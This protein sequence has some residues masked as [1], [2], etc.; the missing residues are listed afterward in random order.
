M[1]NW[2]FVLLFFLEEY[3][4]ILLK[5]GSSFGYCAV[6]AKKQRS[7]GTLLSSSDRSS[8]WVFTAWP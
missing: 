1:F 4:H 7:L 8:P 2:V 3:I 5:L 6:G